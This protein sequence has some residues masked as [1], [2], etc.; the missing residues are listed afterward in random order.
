M[1]LFCS[2]EK[3]ILV[4]EHDNSIGEGEKI[5]VHKKGLLHRAFSVLIFNKNKEMLL[6][7]RGSKKYHSPGL[8]TNTA[9]GHPRPGEEVR[10]AAER[11]LKEEMGFT[12]SLKEIMTYLYKIPF[13]NGLYEHEF[14][15]VFIGHYE[16]PVYPNPEEADG[17]R[18]ETL[19]QIKVEMRAMPEQYTEWFKITMRKGVEKFI[20]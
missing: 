13:A 7:L 2:M 12:V 8:W 18:W 17:Y 4:D 15:H 20:N 6:Q 16:G 3:V 5:D 19:Q 9:C 1:G 14:L 10:A 11:R